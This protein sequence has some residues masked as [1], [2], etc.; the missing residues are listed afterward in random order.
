METKLTEEMP[1]VQPQAGADCPF[2]LQIFNYRKHCWV[3][4]PA[5]RWPDWIRELAVFAEDWTIRQMEVFG[6]GEGDK[7]YRYFIQH[8]DFRRRS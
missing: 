8:R 5:D 2:V 7:V 1:A 3:S 6:P 4:V